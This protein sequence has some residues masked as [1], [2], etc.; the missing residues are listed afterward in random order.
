MESDGEECFDKHEKIRIGDLNHIFYFRLPDDIEYHRTIANREGQYAA[1]LT[2]LQN[3]QKYGD[4]FGNSHY[5]ADDID[6]LEFMT[7]IKFDI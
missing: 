7:G 3:E 6:T 1:L 2:L 4:Y 5:I